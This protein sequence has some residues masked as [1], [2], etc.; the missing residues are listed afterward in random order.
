MRLRGFS[1]GLFQYGPSD[2]LHELL[3]D[4]VQVDPE[5]A[6]ACVAAD[7]VALDLAF[8]DQVA[9]ELGADA[10]VTGGLGNADVAPA[11]D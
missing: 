6:V 8:H 4:L 10:S 3:V 2:R 9:H 7:T 5:G 11:H 1:E